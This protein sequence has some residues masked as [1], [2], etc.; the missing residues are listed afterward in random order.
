M[1]ELKNVSFSY[2]SGKQVIDNLSIAIKSGEVW[3]VLG[4]NGSGKS[5][6]IRCMARLEPVKRGTITLENR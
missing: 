3:A 2:V 4:K 6:M 5:T 1:L